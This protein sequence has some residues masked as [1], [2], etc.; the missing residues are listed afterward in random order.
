MAFLRKMLKRFQKR[1]REEEKILEVA[2]IR[3]TRTQQKVLKAFK[4][5]REMMTVSIAV[6][7]SMPLK[8]VCRELE[9]LDEMELVKKG[10]LSENMEK[11]YFAISG[12]GRN[13]LKY[14]NLV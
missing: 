13:L 12:K 9:A 4:R 3:L 2:H 10:S 11:Q 1:R 14:L 8:Q 5:R 6:K 7:A